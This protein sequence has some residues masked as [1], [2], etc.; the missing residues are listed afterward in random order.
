MSVVRLP[1]VVPDEATRVR[2]ER[3]FAAAWQVK[4][5]L[6]RDA[7]ARVD[8][9]HAAT[10]RRAALSAVPGKA[11]AE[12]RDELG[13]SRAGLERAAYRHLDASGHLK[14]HLS[15]AV[16]M[17]I[18]DEVWAGVER[19]LFPDAT[20]RRHGR[21]RRGSWWGFT[22]IPG[23]ARSHTRPRKWETLRLHGTLDGHL[24]TYRNPA[25]PAELSPVQAA[26]LAGQ[27]TP[28]LSSPG[29]AGRSRGR[30]GRRTAVRHEQVRGISVL[31]QPRRMPAPVPPAARGK[32]LWWEHNG[33]LAIVYSGGPAGARGELVLPVRLPQG[34]G[35]WPHLLYALGD[36]E[37][38]HKVDL[39]R[40]AT[41]RGWVYEAHLMILKPA[42]IPPATRARRV[43][44]PQGRRGGV[45]GNV[46]N[47]A[48]VS[49]P[50]SPD[51]AQARQLDVAPSV[52]S[53][54]L[55]L[56]PAE[57]GDL[58][59]AV[60]KA[61]GRQRALE[62]SRRAANAAQYELSKRQRKRQKRRAER[63]LPARQVPVPGGARR[64]RADGV[65]LQSPRR[66]TLSRS[67]QRIRAR[68]ARAAAKAT[69]ARAGRARQVAG[70]LVGVH[71][72]HL[73]IE[74]CDI[75]TWQ[76]RWGAACARFTPG[77]LIAALARECAATG[78]RLLRASTFTTALSQHCLCGHRTPKTLAERAHRCDGAGGCGLTGDRDLVAAALAAFITFTDPDDPHT[79]R[80]DYRA[81]RH[82]IGVH[83]LSTG[84]Q[85]ALTASTD[86][87]D[88]PAPPGHPGT[89]ATPARPPRRREWKN[90]Q[91]ASARRTRQRAVPT[92]DETRPADKRGGHAGQV[93][94][95]TRLSGGSTKDPP[96]RP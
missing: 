33:P 30:T 54:R 29:R 60:R 67:H 55:T 9:Y 93:Q 26:A 46:S 12:W 69:K 27:P 78:G 14:H 41:A 86:T 58:E 21:P 89:P 66:D 51:P 71:G 43:A 52:V 59:R 49:F 7:R 3:L 38:W 88:T 32:A 11:A 84:P 48:T 6:R 64:A 25:L 17:H 96:D 92:P 82:A 40:R 19:H 42:Y 15:K 36:P 23:R 62:R 13:L 45:D 44:A 83:G 72:P 50:A 85:G 74:D 65:P 90:D 4:R 91:V 37:C 28:V 8:A 5:A 18:A 81:S 77:L 2:V 56:S 80:V 16:A 31:A 34:A 61:R 57:R 95:P 10:S 1:L 20:G 79:A 70:A 35:Q 68:H 47:L 39:V 22:R 75:R 87:L 63:G 24:T 53:T 73:V 94:P 76:R